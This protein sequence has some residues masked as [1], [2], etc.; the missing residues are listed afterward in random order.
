[1]TVS[2]QNQRRLSGPPHFWQ[3][4]QNLTSV[5]GAVRPVLV[6]PRGEAGQTELKGHALFFLR[7]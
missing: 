3:M 6:A 7:G 1:L 4:R 2:D 5:D